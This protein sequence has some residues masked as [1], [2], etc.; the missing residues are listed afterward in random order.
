MVFAG[1]TESE[2]FF[3]KLRGLALVTLALVLL[4]KLQANMLGM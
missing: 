1:V 3:S 4:Q 2:T